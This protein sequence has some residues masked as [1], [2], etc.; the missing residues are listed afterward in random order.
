MNQWNEYDNEFVKEQ[1][2]FGEHNC[3]TKKL[4]LCYNP[5]SIFFSNYKLFYF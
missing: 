5:H 3:L 4:K 2:Q 1:I